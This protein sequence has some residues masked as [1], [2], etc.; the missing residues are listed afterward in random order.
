MKKEFRIGSEI[1]WNPDGFHF[2]GPEETLERRKLLEK[3]HSFFQNRGFLE[4][5]PP[6]FDYSSTFIHHVSDSEQDK[7]FK[8]RDLGGQEIS[9]SMDL[10]LQVV[11]G[12]SGYRGKKG[13]SKVYYT[14]RVFKD[15]SRGMGTRRETLQAGAE[16]LGHSNGNTFKLLLSLINEFLELLEFPGKLTVVLGNILVVSA[17]F[18]KMGLSIEERKVLTGYIYRKDKEQIRILLTEIGVPEEQKNYLLELLF[19]F[20][21]R[22]TQIDKLKDISGKWQLGLEEILEETQDIWKYCSKM[23]HLDLCLDYSLVRDMDYYTGFIFHGYYG[24]IS[25]PVVMGGAYDK[26]F[27]KFSG[28]PKR[29]CGFAFN[30]DTIEELLIPVL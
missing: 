2:L 21:S 14:G 6:S 25:E 27:E 19:G 20:I 18:N 3:V 28:E 10:T 23:N 1:K 7:I 22:E 5:R 17:L 4:V 8:S 16:V 9:P 15:V 11:K 26:L 12:M 29:A 13:S 24:S 30:I